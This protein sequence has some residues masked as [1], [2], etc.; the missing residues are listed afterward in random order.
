MCDR[1]LILGHRSSSL[2][3]IFI[4]SHSLPP[5]WSPIRS[6]SNI[7]PVTRDQLKDADKSEFEAHMKRYE[8]LCLASYAQNKSGVIKKNPRLGPQHITFSADP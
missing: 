5:L 3:R 8:E 7:Q 1:D 4:G 2:R 6:F